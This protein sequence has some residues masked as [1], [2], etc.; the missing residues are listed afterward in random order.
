[1]VV[2]LSVSTAVRSDSGWMG[3]NI[4]VQ[5]WLWGLLRN[6][7]GTAGQGE[8]DGSQQTVNTA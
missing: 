2:K 7:S 4:L 5:N 8:G 6:E 1:M 3:V